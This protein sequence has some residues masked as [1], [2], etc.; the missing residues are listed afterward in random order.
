MMT[1][2]NQKLSKG[3]FIE[4]QYTGKIKD[5]NE[6]FDTNIEEEAKKINLDV[7][8][9]PLIIC[10]GQNMILPSI[11]EFLI[12]KESG[13]EYILFLEPEKAFGKRNRN[14]IKTM[15]FSVF[16][17]HNLNPEKGMVFTF[18]N[19]IGKITTVSGGR[20][21]V[22]FNNPLASKEVVYELRV[23][24]KVIDINEKVNSIM[25]FFLRKEFSF[26]IKEKKLIIKLKKQEENFKKFIESF[27]ENFKET[28]SLDLE[29]QELKETKK[30]EK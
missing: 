18:D 26:E 17:K 8:T 22:D 5:T 6:I 23:K 15:P 2:K 19:V 30:K 1:E 27:K 24:R 11:D 28:L 12:G 7:K 10:L 21:I 29:V 16:S 3:D 14:L 9:K 25:I 13:K 20:V 4:L